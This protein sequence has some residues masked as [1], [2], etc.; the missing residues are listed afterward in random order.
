MVEPTRRGFINEFGNRIS[1]EV[2]RGAPDHDAVCTS[3]R[4]RGHHSPQCERIG[5]PWPLILF[6]DGATLIRIEGP[7]SVSENTLTP[8]EVAEL[9]AA[10]E[11]HLHGVS[12]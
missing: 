1:I 8:M 3:C 6:A 4:W 12:P 7:S 11:A 5:E 9:S 2:S 10:L